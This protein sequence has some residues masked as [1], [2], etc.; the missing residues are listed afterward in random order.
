MPH[1]NIRRQNIVL[2][3]SMVILSSIVLLATGTVSYYWASYL[4]CNYRLSSL[5]VP[6]NQAHYT[7]QTVL[8]PIQKGKVQGLQ[9]K[10]VRSGIVRDKIAQ[11]NTYDIVTTNKASKEQIKTIAKKI[12]GEIA[13]K[14]KDVD[15]IYLVFYSNEK[16]IKTK[17]FDIA[18][19][20]WQPK[21]GKITP[22]IAKQNIRT[23]YIIRVITRAEIE[24]AKANKAKPKAKANQ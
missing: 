7:G 21:D 4:V 17:P 12:V 22:E 1:P 14:D 6:V 15:E 19:A 2:L 10:I 5:T 24:K 11:I 3:T 13:S 8:I 16:L 9:Y 23:N 18:E 20:I